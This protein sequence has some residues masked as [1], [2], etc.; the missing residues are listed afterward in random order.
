VTA[1]QTAL[2]REM[3]LVPVP[4]PGAGTTA[5]RA[6]GRGATEGAVAPVAA[7]LPDGAAEATSWGVARVAQAGLAVLA[8]VAIGIVVQIALLSHLEYRSSQVASLNSF[9]T[10]LAFGTAPLGPVG[11]DHHLL[12]LGTPIAVITIPALGVRSVVLEG[13]TGSVLTKGPGHVRTSVFPGGAGAS[14]LYG[15]AG[16]YGGPFGRIG[17]LHR[18]QMITV[19]TQVGTSHF[20][21]IRVRPAGARVRPPA[22]GT[23]RLT[24]GTATGGFLTPS[25]VIW[26]DAAKVG[27]PLAASSPPAITLLPSEAPLASD[28]TTLWALLLWL[29]GLGILLTLAVW[30]W[31]RWGHAQAWIIFT[32][33]MLVVWVFISDQIVRLLPNM[34]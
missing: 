6:P 24:L 12:A 2:D 8:V 20:R 10:Q 9:R 1:T 4:A 21:V 26:V 11:P 25:G 7:A 5:E 30:T 18:G 16:T 34:I 3:L 31:R 17:D 28:T 32:A 29:E 13:T 23:S 14:V 22:P 33:P 27:A 15:R 19:V